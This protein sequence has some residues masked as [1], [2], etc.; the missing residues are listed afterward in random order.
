MSARKF[1]AVPFYREAPPH[2]SSML[3]NKELQTGDA[4]IPPFRGPK[5]AELLNLAANRVQTRSSIYMLDSGSF[6]R[7]IP[8]PLAEAKSQDFRPF[9][10]KIC[11]IVAQVSTINGPSSFHQRVLH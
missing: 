9:W 2:V 4:E 8:T 11:G 7:G 5:K 3:V 1:V 6:R 10:L